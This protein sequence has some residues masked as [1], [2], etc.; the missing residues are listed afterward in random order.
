[1]TY[2]Q[3]PRLIFNIENFCELAHKYEF[4]S[5][6]YF[7]IDPESITY[8]ERLKLIC[9]ILAKYLQLFIQNE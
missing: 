2:P 7:D 3:N 6:A 5:H 9:L 8:L 1:M 4:L